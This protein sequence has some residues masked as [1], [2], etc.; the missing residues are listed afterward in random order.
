MPNRRTEIL[1]ATS[2]AT[3][4]A[5]QYQDERRTS[6]DVQAAILDR[7]IPI[8]YR[9]LKKL[10]GATVTTDEGGTGVLITTQLPF[11]VQRFTLAHE[12]GH[13]VLGHKTKF[14][15][16][17]GQ[18]LARDPGATSIDEIAADTFASEL[19]APQSRILSLAE[20]HQWGLSDLHQPPTIY[21][22]SL[23]L[24]I[25]FQAACWALASNGLLA[26][27]AAQRLSKTVVKKLKLAIAGSALEDP[28][29]D[30][31][32]LSERDGGSRIEAGPGDV[33]AVELLEDASSGYLWEPV[34]PDTRWQVVV[35]DTLPDEKYGSPV[36]RTTFLKIPSQGTHRVGFAHRRP[37]NGQTASE[38]DIT[39]DNWGKEAEG[40]PRKMREA[41]LAGAAG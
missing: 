26:L 16:S 15:H 28:W 13:I 19:L 11:T 30:A 10:M 12:L 18:W 4:I 40:F 29:A 33:F 21:Q 35:Q 32:R 1:R 25:S 20:R 6:F 24:G 38:F 31:W 17:V 34:N 14:D 2:E 5:Q 36:P 27:D 22:L 37:W 3:L 9:P 41:A 39:I 8:I 7:G 23:R